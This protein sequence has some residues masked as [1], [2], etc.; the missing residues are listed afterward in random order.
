MQGFWLK[1][2]HTIIPIFTV[3]PFPKSSSLS[4]ITYV[5]GWLL[6][7]KH[8]GGPGKPGCGT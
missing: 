2:A 7:Q 6:P 8:T 1:G 3:A 4:Q 5:R